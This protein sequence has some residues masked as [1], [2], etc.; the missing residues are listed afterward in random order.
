MISSWWQLSLIALPWAIAAP[1]VALW[2]LLNLGDL[3]LRLLFLLLQ[4]ESRPISLP[5]SL[6][7]AWPYSASALFIPWIL[8]TIFLFRYLALNLYFSFLKR[9]YFPLN[10]LFFLDDIVYVQY[11]VVLNLF[12]AL[13]DLFNPL[14]FHPIL[15][16]M[17]HH[18]IRQLLFTYE[19]LT[20]F[21]FY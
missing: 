14:L 17:S 12:R 6:P 1:N 15:N 10:L 2:W 11:N 13:F 9:A 16:I 8:S 20:F 5:W 4:L 19:L 18:M 7:G 21:A 3:Q